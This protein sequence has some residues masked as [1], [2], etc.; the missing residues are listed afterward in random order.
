L[1]LF[2][3]EH[4]DYW[5]VAA[6]KI[7]TTSLSKCPE[8][9]RISEEVHMFQKP[10]YWIVRNPIG[11]IL[12]QWHWV[13]SQNPDTYIGAEFG[14]I[15][16]IAE[17]KPFARDFE[18]FKTWLEDNIHKLPDSNDYHWGSQHN[19]IRDLGLSPDQLRIMPVESLNRLLPN[20]QRFNSSIWKF[21]LSRKIAH[22]Q[23]KSIVVSHF[24]KDYNVYTQARNS[25]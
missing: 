9:E 24:Q 1:A 6:N 7:A 19:F 18:Y 23:I 16:S 11:R 3:F 15:E 5:I 14:I 13:F 22:Q 20:I 17:H 25:E 2:R 4:K 12:S 21:K 10:I 8:L